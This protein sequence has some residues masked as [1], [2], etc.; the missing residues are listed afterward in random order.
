MRDDTLF[1]VGNWLQGKGD[2]WNKIEQEGENGDGGY[3]FSQEFS[4]E[5]S[6][7]YGLAAF[8]DRG[9]DIIG[10]RPYYH[11]SCDGTDYEG[12]DR[13]DWK[14]LGRSAD[15]KAIVLRNADYAVPARSCDPRDLYYEQGQLLY[16]VFARWLSEGKPRWEGMGR[17]YHIEHGAEEPRH[18]RDDDQYFGD[19]LPQEE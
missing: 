17:A 11:C 8:Y 4:D 18:F 13:R 2:L 10:I 9:A 12:E 7:V 15:L 16:L 3:F 19:G 6:G 1:R 5:T 14:F